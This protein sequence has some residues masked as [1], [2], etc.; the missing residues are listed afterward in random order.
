MNAG[1]SRIPI[2][3]GTDRNAILGT[4]LVKQLLLNDPD[5]E[6]PLSSVKLKKLPRVCSDT[7]LFDMLHVF[8]VGASHMALVVDEI[9]ANIP[10]ELN[11]MLDGTYSPR[12]IARRDHSKFKCLG[13]ITLE[14]VIEELIGEEVIDAPYIRLLTR[15]MSMLICKPRLEFQELNVRLV[16]NGAMKWMKGSN[17]L[18]IPPPLVLSTRILLFFTDP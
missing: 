18:R 7:P 3:L 10:E 14:D 16:Q 9:S 6:T 8:E 1:H 13:I 2:Y 15:L 17:Y 4:L 12:W 5:D 11:Q